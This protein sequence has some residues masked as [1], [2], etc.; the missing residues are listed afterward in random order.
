MLPD[1]LQQLEFDKMLA[2]LRSYARSPLGEAKLLAL[3]PAA[4]EAEPAAR[5]RLAAEAKEY[6]RASRGTEGVPAGVLP[7]DFS[8]FTD[9]AEPAAERRQ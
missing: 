1:T 4:D 3:V 2:L 6:L 9:P 5:L 7:L 8:G